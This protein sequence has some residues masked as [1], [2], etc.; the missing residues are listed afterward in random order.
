MSLSDADAYCD[1]ALTLMVSVN[2]GC[3]DGPDSDTI[4]K[5]DFENKLGSWNMDT[6]LDMIIYTH[7]N[8]FISHIKT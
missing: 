2:L 1:C 4:W 5:M 8:N 3:V 6:A 7:E